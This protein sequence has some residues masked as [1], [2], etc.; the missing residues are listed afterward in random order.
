MGFDVKAMLMRRFREELEKLSS[1]SGDITSHTD[2]LASLLNDIEFEINVLRSSFALPHHAVSETVPDWVKD[3]NDAEDADFQLPE[4]LRGTGEDNGEEAV[5]NAILT[6]RLLAIAQAAEKAR[7]GGKD[8]VYQTGCQAL[9]ISKATLLRKIKQVSAKPPRKQ[10]V[11]YGTSALTRDE[12]LLISGVITKSKRNNSKRLYSL[13]KTVNDL[14][15]NNLINAGH[16]DN[17][18]GEWFPLSVDAINRA[19]YQYRLHPNQL[20]APAPCIQLKTDHPNHVWQL[21]A[22][23]CVLYYLKNPEKV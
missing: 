20:R 14:R 12:A 13:E 19:L 2:Y 21:D 8:A 15:A 17:E 22:S 11:D 18:T 16:V 3:D 5:M 6:K 9:G 1:H 23:L 7:H 4:H 10:R